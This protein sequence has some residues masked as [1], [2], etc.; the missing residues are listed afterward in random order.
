MSLD[1]IIMAK[2]LI[3]IKMNIDQWEDENLGFVQEVA[4]F[5]HKLLKKKSKKGWGSR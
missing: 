1:D 3:Y 2:S 5:V 4:I